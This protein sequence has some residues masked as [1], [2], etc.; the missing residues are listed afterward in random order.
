MCTVVRWKKHGFYPILYD[1]SVCHD[2]H[3]TQL[4]DTFRSIETETELIYYTHL[5]VFNDTL[6]RVKT[7]NISLIQCHR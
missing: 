5:R 2:R 3:T 1:H 4:N 6:A 7:G